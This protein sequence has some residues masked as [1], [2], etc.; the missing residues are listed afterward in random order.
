MIILI[1]I[2]FKQANLNLLPYL[3]PHYKSPLFTIMESPTLQNRA[4]V[5]Y[6]DLDFPIFQGGMFLKA[7]IYVVI[8]LTKINLKIYL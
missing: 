8:F 7:C 2:S 5:V 4:R 3:P 6:T 1:F